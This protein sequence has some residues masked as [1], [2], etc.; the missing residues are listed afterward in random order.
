MNFN[1]P[2][3]D[4]QLLVTCNTLFFARRQAEAIR[5]MPDE[6]ATAEERRLQAEHFDWAGDVM[7]EE[8]LA[9]IIQQSRKAQERANV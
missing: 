1:V 9:Y 2:K 3:D 8:A 6:P 4:Q 5:Q 7:A